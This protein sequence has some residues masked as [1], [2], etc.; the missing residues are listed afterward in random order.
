MLNHLFVRKRDLLGLSHDD[1][2]SVPAVP[3]QSVNRTVLLSDG[4]FVE[5]PLLPI[6][7]E[8]I[9]KVVDGDGS[10]VSGR[11]HLLGQY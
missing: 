8:K 2:R 6:M 1:Q 3:G 4:R 5:V 9:L 10:K 7:L 11:S